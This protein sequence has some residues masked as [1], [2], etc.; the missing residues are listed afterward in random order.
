MGL[1]GRRIP[2]P[3]VKLHYQDSYN[4]EYVIGMVNMDRKSSWREVDLKSV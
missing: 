2:E 3:C 4:L 1:K